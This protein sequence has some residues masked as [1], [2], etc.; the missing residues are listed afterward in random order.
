[1]EIYKKE[2]MCAIFLFLLLLMISSFRKTR[3][4]ILFGDFCR[5]NTDIHGLVDGVIPK[6]LN[7]ILKTSSEIHVPR[8]EAGVCRVPSRNFKGLCMSDT[9]CANV[10]IGEGFTGGDC[11]GLRRRCLCQKPC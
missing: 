4:N 3:N 8:V 2:T 9:N 1:M 11:D 10:C 7:L 5:T 6:R